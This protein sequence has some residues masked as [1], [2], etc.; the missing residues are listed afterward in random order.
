MHEPSSRKLRIS[1]LIA[2][3]SV[4]MPCALPGCSSGEVAQD[5]KVGSTSSSVAP[6]G[7]GQANHTALPTAP[8]HEE[9]RRSMLNIRLPG[10]GCF[11]AV[12][13]GTHW[14]EVPCN[15]A[16]KCPGPGCKMYDVGGDISPSLETGGMT[17]GGATISSAEGSFQVT[18]VSSVYSEHLSGVTINGEYSVQLNTTSDF[19][20]PVC[21]GA[22]DPAHCYSA[23]QFVF[24]N[25]GSSCR[26]TIVYWI[27]NYGDSCPLG[28]AYH[29]DSSCVKRGPSIDIAENQPITN[30][31]NLKLTATVTSDGA[32][33][34]TLST[35]S[36]IYALNPPG[37]ESYANLA[38]RWNFV[39][40]NVFGS[41]GSAR[42]VFNPNATILVRT[43]LTSTTTSSPKYLNYGLT[44]ETNN[45]NVVPSS[46]CASGG[47]HLAFQFLESN[48]SPPP[49]PPFC[50]LNDITPIEFPL[51]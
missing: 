4:V 36:D 37:Q 2:I 9:W 47:S 10:K 8:S 25:Y 43:T 35:G 14:N 42:A 18:N 29:G 17:G 20:V 5:T 39:E 34:L 31:A 1:P 26:L 41:D 16:P 11:H 12:H 49:Q 50:L 38:Q 19:N 6:R 45:L 23:P 32:D 3:V 51:Q 24:A 27:M 21:A 15:I 30:L 33:T 40:F 7:G 48:A 44:A 13:P 28:W 46:Y 22:A